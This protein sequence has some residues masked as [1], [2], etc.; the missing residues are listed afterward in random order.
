MF[1]SQS[2]ARVI[3][4]WMA[5]D[6]AQK[7]S[8]SIAEYFSMMKGLADDM[9]SAGKKLD[10]EKVASY[11]LAGLDGEYNL[12]VSAVAARTDPI[13]LGELYTQLSSFEQCCMLLFGSGS[14]SSSANMASRGG[15]GTGYTNTNNRGRGRG[16]RQGSDQ[17]EHPH[18]PAVWEGRAHR[19]AL[20]QEVRRQLS[21]TVGAQVCLCCLHHVIWH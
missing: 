10:D 13:S 2:R 3:N 1:S 14:G 8:S 20:L 4:V 12:V 5:L 19:L 9:A 11:I 7:G 16:G 15:R 17:S 18:L 6:T 21:G